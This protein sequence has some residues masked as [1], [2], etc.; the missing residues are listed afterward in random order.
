MDVGLRSVP[1]GT[2][3]PA[4]VRSGGT[5]VRGHTTTV[6]VALLV[7]AA[8]GLMAWLLLSALSAGPPVSAAE[9]SFAVRAFAINRFGY[10]AAQLPWYDGGLGALQVAGYETVSGALRRSAT[11]VS[12]ARE[13][14]AVA[15]VLS[16]VALTVAARRL[17]LSAPAVVAVALLFGLAPAALLLHR[18]ADPAQLGVLWACVALA[19]AGGE[20]RRVGAALGSAAYLLAAAVTSPLVLV[21]LVPLFAMLLWSGALARLRRRDRRVIAAAGLVVY[22]GL[23]LLAARGDLPG[24]GQAAVPELTALDWV[25]A[26]A[27]VG[28]GL[29]GLRIGWLRPLAVALLA[30]VLA[31]AVSPDLRGSLLL[32]A[33]PLGAVVLPAA[34]ESVLA[35]VPGR[36]TWLPPRPVLA[37]ALAVVAVLAWVLSAG[38]IREPVDGS[39]QAATVAAR[40]W[41]LQNLPSRPKLVVDDAMWGDLVDAGYPADALV[42]A[43]GVGPAQA[44]WPQGW[45]D[46]GYV[47]GSDQGLLGAGDPVRTARQN[48]TPVAS[49]GTGAGAVSVRRVITDPDAVATATEEA[50]G[51]AAAGGALAGNPRLGLQPAAAEL[52]RDG[53]VDSRAL[54]VLA[55]VSGDHALQIVDFPVVA[56][57]NPAMPRRLIAISAIDNQTVAAGSAAVSLLDQWLRAQLPPYKPAGTQ[58]SQIDGRSVLL[59]RYDALGSTGLLPP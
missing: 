36:R 10:G 46:A 35:A 26:V 31:A 3:Q 1:A 48:S 40:T 56:G 51:R 7:L 5:L 15:S 20:S 37:G 4:P 30:T 6:A 42:A 28:G 12:A 43:G 44:A 17:R 25:L 45:R 23:L 27:A 19:L 55:A 41:V 14:A 57:E 54:S 21:A 53:Q 2:Q 39:R 47:V 32:V 50:A 13:A 9:T 38:G 11:A 29:A 58:L 16:A 22:A 34:A 59:V 24:G 49:F 18:T 33:L 8:V 52:L